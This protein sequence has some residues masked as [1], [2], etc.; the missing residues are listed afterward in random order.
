MPALPRRPLVLVVDDQASLR[1]L[2]RVNLELEGFEVVEAAD[3]LECLE[4]ARERR[5]DVITL[6]VV[7]PR[8]DGLAAAAELHADADLHDVPVVIVTTSNHPSD[9]ARARAAGVDAYLTKPYDPDELVLAVRDVLGP[10]T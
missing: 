2:I 1:S 6:D 5:P 10:P 9:L 4:R 8:M 3:G 7:M